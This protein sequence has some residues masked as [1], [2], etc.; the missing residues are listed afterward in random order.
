MADLPSPYSVT[1]RKLVMENY[2][3]RSF[4]GRVVAGEFVGPDDADGRAPG[5]YITI[6]LDDIN[7]GLVGGPARVTYLPLNAS[8]AVNKERAE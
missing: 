7:A 3:G 2:T 6:R 1:P 4:D 8:A 5:T